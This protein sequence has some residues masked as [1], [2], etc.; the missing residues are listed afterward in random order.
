MVRSSGPCPGS[1]TANSGAQV[2]QF[3]WDADTNTL[4]VGLERNLLV[5]HI[6]SGVSCRR[7]HRRKSSAKSLV[8]QLWSQKP[9]A[10]RTL[11]QLDTPSCLSQRVA[12][13]L[14]RQHWM[15]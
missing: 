7:T 15:T 3:A 2:L 11:L 12:R 14:Q 9:Q 10:S 1:T 4:E 5:Q 8:K 6:H 13:P